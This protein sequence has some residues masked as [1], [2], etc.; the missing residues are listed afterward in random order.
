MVRVDVMVMVM[1]ILGL[2]RCQGRI[3]DPVRL[4]LGL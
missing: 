2:V 4:G 3:Y 1:V